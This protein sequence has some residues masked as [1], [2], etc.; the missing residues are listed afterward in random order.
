MDQA[1]S[2]VDV[3]ARVMDLVAC[4]ARSPNA[5]ASGL[6]GGPALASVPRARS[7]SPAT[8]ACPAANVDERLCDLDATAAVF[9]S[10]AETL[11]PFDLRAA[12]LEGGQRCFVEVAEDAA[13]GRLWATVARPGQARLIPLGGPIAKDNPEPIRS[14]AA[15]RRGVALGASSLRVEVAEAPR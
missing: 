1:A 12:V 7:A 13:S 3:A 4:S 14:L 6:G 15:A 2:P 10:Y 11:N 8:S 5:P 9:R